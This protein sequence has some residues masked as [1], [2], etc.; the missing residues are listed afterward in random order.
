MNFQF[1]SPHSSW[2]ILACLAAG[3]LYAFVLYRNDSAF[4]ELNIWLR[5]PMFL[6]RTITVFLIA[7]FLLSPM[8]KSTTRQVEKPIVIIAQD[9]S[10]SVPMHKDSSFYRNE[11][12]IGMK[13]LSEELSGKYEVRNYSWGEK[14]SDG[15]H[16]S[17][18]EKETD[19][20]GILDELDTRFLNRNVGAIIIASDGLYN[21]GVNPLYR[22]GLLKVPLYTIALG[23]TTVQRDVLISDVR[24][25]RTAYLNNSFPLEIILQARHCSGN[26]VTLDVTE[27]NTGLFTKNIS[28]SNNNFTQKI[29][30]YLEAKTKGNH[31]YRI[32]VSTV[33]GEVTPANNVRDVYIEVVEH[34]QKILFVSSSSHPDV[35]AIHEAIESNENYEVTLTKAD[36]FDK[37]LSDYDMAIL[38]QLPSQDGNNSTVA[39]SVLK[40]NLPRLFVLGNQT[41]IALFNRLNAGININGSRQK[42]NEPLAVVENSF[43]IFS[44]GDETV[45]GINDMPPLSAPFGEY[46]SGTMNN[47]ML[48]QKIGSVNS[49]IP[50][51][52]FN[53][54]E[55][56][57]TGIIAGEG[58]WRWRLYDFQKHGNFNLTNELLTKT[59][60]YLLVK[61][62]KSRFRLDAKNIYNENESVIMQ[63]EVF[64]ETLELMNTAEV[65][66]IITNDKKNNFP[67]TFTNN[68]KTYSLNSG[69]FPVGD[70]RYKATAKAGNKI[71]AAEGGFSVSPVQIEQSE[72]VAD[73]RLLFTLSQKSGGTM[74]YPNEF[75]KLKDELLKRNDLT[76]ESYMHTKLEELLN[77]KWLFF[78]ILLLLGAEWFLRK[79][80]GAY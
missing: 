77:K 3:I 68:G 63:A 2:L 66:I 28:V 52:L 45:S 21:K 57:R 11:Y 75:E 32:M 6:L 72:T 56:V 14:I 42:S 7:L 74:F 29:P 8:L 60:Q 69:Y 10:S 9:N 44:L 36:G 62:N 73:H 71:L 17:F 20:S 1:S 43:S 47:V 37:K 55:N 61:E 70:Y 33:A 51:W 16:M 25:N 59:V 48:S 39:D 30:V 67:F 4:K 34:K 64:D 15:L 65:S 58:L 31:H 53:E 12:A 27:N 80:S 54:K 49:G 18:S 5:R 13:K 40:Q 19:M 38:Y 24:Y 23:D 76:S 35:G 22:N 79:R 46:K 78:L 41:D 50:L 26:N